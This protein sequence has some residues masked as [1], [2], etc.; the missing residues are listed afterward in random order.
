MEAGKAPL[1]HRLRYEVDLT[2]FN[3]H[4]AASVTRARA[5]MV[6]ASRTDLGNLCTG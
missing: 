3:P 6:E 1:L 2:G 5:A 4:G